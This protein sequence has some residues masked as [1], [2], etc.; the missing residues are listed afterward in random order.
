[1]IFLKKPDFADSFSE[2]LHSSYIEDDKFIFYNLLKEL[3]VTEISV[4]NKVDETLQNDK[5][6]NGLDSLKIS[7]V[8][9]CLSRFLI[10][11]FFNSLFNKTKER[12]FNLSI[13]EE[14]NS[15][16]ELFASNYIAPNFRK[17][18]KAKRTPNYMKDASFLHLCKLFTIANPTTSNKNIRDSL[19]IIYDID[20]I[21]I[22]GEEVKL[23]H[24]KPY[25]KGY[26]NSAQRAIREKLW[27]EVYESSFK[28]PMPN[29]WYMIRYLSDL[30]SN[31]FKNYFN[32]SSSLNKVR[33]ESQRLLK[34]TPMFK[35]ELINKLVHNN[36]NN[37]YD[38]NIHKIPPTNW[39]EIIGTGQYE[40]KGSCS[41]EKVT[42]DFI[43]F[44]T[45]S[46]ELKLLDR[47]GLYTMY[48]F[49]LDS[50]FELALYLIFS[51]TLGNEV[52]K[53]LIDISGN[54][55]NDIQ[56]FAFGFI[57][58]EHDLSRS[59]IKAVK[60]K[61]SL[62]LSFAKLIFRLKKEKVEA[63][64]RCF[65]LREEHFPGFKE[66]ITNEL[67]TMPTSEDLEK[68]EED[69]RDYL[70]SLWSEMNNK[71]DK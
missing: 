33:L 68:L 19:N 55:I 4:F 51:D 57:K 36:P 24:N 30:E 16:V 61:P 39:G 69:Q 46:N 20:S 17:A 54:E 45:L 59:I 50:R 66:I 34:E 62:V 52:R 22:F 58:H 63:L 41:L 18:P 40:Y 42:H 23:N 8:K 21:S 7:E 70:W 1:V 15:T 37:H 12:Y 10:G 43:K 71:K 44:P 53:A 67:P 2:R 48:D 26:V 49:S 31:E 27:A 13:S 6:L 35:N 11:E 25:D 5:L 14:I 60:R 65:S 32:A 28:Q 56:T 64:A 9:W 29:L 3:E 38:L 47:Y